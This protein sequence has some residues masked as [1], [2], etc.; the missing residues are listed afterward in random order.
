MRRLFFIVC[1]FLA[2]DICLAD[3]W[4]K[5]NFIIGAHWGPPLHHKYNNVDSP[6]VRNFTLLKDGGF[7]FIVGQM[8]PHNSQAESYLD[9]NL[10]DLITECNLNELYFLVEKKETDTIYGVD[11][12]DEPKIEE[13]EG[14]LR[15]VDTLIQRNPERLGF[16]NLL[17]SY[18]K[19]FNSF[20]DFKI[21]ADS[22][23]C[24][25]I[26]SLQVACFDNYNPHSQ[27][28]THA[29]AQN[30]N[31]YS[32]LAYMKQAAGSRPLWAYL[33]SSEK[34]LEEKDDDWQDA[35]IRLGA[36]APLA[37]G[38][39][40][41]LYFC[42]DCK[43]RNRILRSLG[44]GAWG[45]HVIFFDNDEKSRQIF[46]GN[47]KRDSTSQCPDLLVHT[48]DSRGTWRILET[49]SV[50]LNQNMTTIGTWFG[51]H[52]HNIPNLYNWDFTT[53][54]Y[55]KFT[56][57]QSSERRL[58]LSKFRSGWTHYADLSDFPISYWSTM[59]RHTCPF[60]DFNENQQLDFCLGWTENRH[61]KL[62][63]YMDCHL[64][65]S[66]TPTPRN[67]PMLFD[68]ISQTFTFNSP[69]KQVIASRDSFLYVITSNPDSTYIHSD[70][71]YTFKYS[72]N[73]FNA[74]D[75]SLITLPMEMDHYWMEE[76]LCGQA[77]DGGVWR[78]VAAQ[79]YNMTY[80]IQ[81]FS[82]SDIYLWGQYNNRSHQY[83][84][85][86]LA[87]EKLQTYALLDR[88]GNP[89]RIYYTAKTINQFINDSIKSIIMDETWLGAYF[90][91]MPMQK[92][93]IP[94]IKAIK[95]TQDN[96]LPLIIKNYALTDDVLFGLFK[97][98]YDNLYLLVINMEKRT[99]NLIFNIDH[100]ALLP[101]I[102]QLSPYTYR[103]DKITRMNFAGNTPPDVHT[104]YT[105]ITLDSM[106]GGECAILHLTKIPVP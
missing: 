17:P 95:G 73:Q 50:T 1:C 6:L 13:A 44:R 99:R 82:S 8:N 92:D 30:G 56:T 3:E 18:W 87:S 38:A 22:F 61:G 46:F 84:R 106:L 15:K 7:N 4:W 48:N 26:T 47:V 28:S 102:P 105:R 9:N 16:I 37:F 5:D 63:I 79:T 43:D 33:R 104:N 11:F 74:V 2:L 101:Q 97:D 19:G 52:N 36:F 12:K 70:S 62:R 27:F 65:P 83:D 10:S 40:G 86:G 51:D 67:N 59:S 69:I 45:D 57:I 90:S 39:K 42:Y 35:Y 88:K 80:K 91:S 64:D 53:D 68:N 54:G 72:S 100:H 96:P 32:N 31:Y 71:I 14:L 58:L 23:L 20:N 66:H 103:C 60:G 77:T 21:Y 98:A 89:N 93:T 49:D 76:V 75:T 41:I 85:Y 94:L 29:P 78:E 24:N 34:F 81:G 25:T 55:D